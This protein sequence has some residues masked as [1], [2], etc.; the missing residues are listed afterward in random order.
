MSSIMRDAPEKQPIFRHWRSSSKLTTLS[1]TSFNEPSASN[2]LEGDDLLKYLR[3]INYCEDAIYKKEMNELKWV[4]SLSTSISG[5]LLS[6]YRELKSIIT[7]SYKRSPRA[8][9]NSSG[10]P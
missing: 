1:S 6:V 10:V 3:S 8:S 9:T 4:V 2:T 5:C 7:Y